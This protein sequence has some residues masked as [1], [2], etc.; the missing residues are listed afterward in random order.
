MLVNFDSA[1]CHGLAINVVF[2]LPS[3]HC[4]LGKGS[5]LAITT[6]N[7]EKAGMDKKHGS[8]IAIH[9]FAR[10]P[11]LFLGNLGT[12]CGHFSDILHTAVWA[13]T[14]NDSITFY[15]HCSLALYGRL[16]SESNFAFIRGS[17][18]AGGFFT[19]VPH[20]AYITA[21]TSDW[22]MGFFHAF[23][24]KLLKSYSERCT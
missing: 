1:C 14:R 17:L 5:S 18:I 8:I 7:G 2:F 3:T 13:L 21:C 22:E 6:L 11:L 10:L 24:D 20:A 23:W 4:M 15:S 12:W 19:F 16:P 9:S